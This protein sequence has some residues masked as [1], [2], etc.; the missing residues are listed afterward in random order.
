MAPGWP[1][2]TADLK[3]VIRQNG[4]LAACQKQA[5]DFRLVSRIPAVLF[6][7]LEFEHHVGAEVARRPSYQYAD[8]VFLRHRTLAPSVS[9]AGIRPSAAMLAWPEA[10][11]AAPSGGPE[12]ALGVLRGVLGDV[13]RKSCGEGDTAGLTGAAAMAFRYAF[14]L[15]LQRRSSNGALLFCGRPLRAALFDRV[16][17]GRI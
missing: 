16:L 17:R 1:L 14:A 8:T 11:V 2:R 9:A 10:L 12:W 6:E 15:T 3:Q 4:R 13:G 5:H 7:S